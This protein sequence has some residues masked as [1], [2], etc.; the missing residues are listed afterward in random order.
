M[1]YQ[2]KANGFEPLMDVNGRKSEPRIFFP[3]ISAEEYRR[4]QINADLNRGIWS[5]LSKI[6][7]DSRRLVPRLVFAPLVPLCGNSGLVAGSLA[8]ARA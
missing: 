3:Q 1:D 5:G 2:F 4:T 8:A 6:G 7:T